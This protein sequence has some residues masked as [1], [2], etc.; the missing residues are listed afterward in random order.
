MARYGFAQPPRI[1]DTAGAIACLITDGW[2]GLE[3]FLKPGHECLTALNGDEV[4]THHTR[5]RSGNFC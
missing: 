3:L 1:F 5:S 2:E 4:V